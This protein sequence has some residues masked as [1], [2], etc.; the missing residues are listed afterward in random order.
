MQCA[1]S[2]ILV[3]ETLSNKVHSS[4]GLSEM[5]HKLDKYVGKATDKIQCKAHVIVTYLVFPVWLVLS[6][7][8]YNIGWR[9]SLGTDRV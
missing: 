2:D 6:G 5:R 8:L 1:I 4:R 3:R 7:E 9:D